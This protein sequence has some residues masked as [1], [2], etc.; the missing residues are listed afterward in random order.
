M[1]LK[2]S[3]DRLIEW[4]KTGTNDDLLILARAIRTELVCRVNQ[5][6][7]LGDGSMVNALCA[8]AREVFAPN[9]TW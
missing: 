9:T 2:M 6:D 4:L 7:S 8:A 5:A 1:T 3:E